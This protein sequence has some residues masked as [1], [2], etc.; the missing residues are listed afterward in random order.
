MASMQD[1]LNFTSPTYGKV[2]LLGAIAA[3]SAFI[4]T[5][6]IVVL[7]VGCQRKGKTHN[8][9]SES[10]KHRLMDMSILRQSKLRSISK[11]DG[12]MNK[13]NCNGKK[14]SKK[15]RPASMDLL[16]SRRSNSDLRSGG[17]TLPQIPSGTGED[18]E[19]TYSE[20]GQRSSPK[21]GPDNNLYAIVGRAGETDTP[22]PPAVPANTPAPPD[23]D[24]DGLNEPL[25]EPEPMP[26]AM[27]HPQPPET[28]A[29][30]ACVRKLRK[31]DKAVPQKRDSGT[32]M[33]EAPVP[34]PRHAPPSH[35]APPPPHPQHP[36]SMKMPR[37]N[38]D[39]FKLPTFPKE[40]VFMGNGEQYIW[41]PPEDDDITMLQNKPL[42]PQSPHSGENIKPST[43]LVAEMYSKVCKPGKKK[44]AVPGSPPA[45]IGFR[46]LGRGDRD[47]ERDGGFSVVVKPQTW[48]PQEG[49]PVG[50]ASA[51]LEDHCYESIET[52]EECD[53]TYEP[54]EG[55][56][57]WKRVGGTE[58][59]P[60]TCATLRPRRKKSQQPLQQPPPPPP[61]QQTPKLQ[62]H[63]AKALLLPGE[64]LYESIGELKQGGTATS[65]T[66]TIFTF[67]D[68]MEMYVTGL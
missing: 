58:R 19:H 14:S 38:V 2:L 5:I 50:G 10:G 22:A 7:C 11:S 12:E 35:P 54:M 51:T 60:N 64:N 3:A 62:H 1:G 16:P 23:L 68:G 18:G 63:P 52:G 25:P 13:L 24:G 26:Q 17:R 34:P 31:V 55:G 49:K 41:K 6:L 33:G 53:P 20:V 65:S 44:R 45:N 56:G 28:T 36:H 21:R 8:V 46:T 67:N 59:P 47:R 27:A 42:G 39:A 43:A 9:S 30:Y 48:A 40:A 57:S 4:V 37:K 29:E 32:D 15:N 66:T 61:T